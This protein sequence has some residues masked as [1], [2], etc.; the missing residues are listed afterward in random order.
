MKEEEQ[1]VF[2]MAQTLEGVPVVVLGLPE[3]AWEYMKDGKTHT[4]DFTKVNVPLMLV[5]FGGKSRE[6]IIEE[7]RS[8]GAQWGISIKDEPPQTYGI[9]EKKPN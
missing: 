3:A 7:L 5:A 8:K 4:F 1:I 6:T 9:D 2:M